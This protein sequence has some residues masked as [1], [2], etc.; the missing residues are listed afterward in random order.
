MKQPLLTF[1][2]EGQWV[3]PENEVPV[4][5]LREDGGDWGDVTTRAIDT[6]H[7]RYQSL[8]VE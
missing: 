3:E 4:L 5:T 7:K 6:V 8:S 2:D 1:M